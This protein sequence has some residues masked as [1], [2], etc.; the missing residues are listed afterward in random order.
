[1]SEK[2]AAELKDEQVKEA[3][4]ALLR[5]RVLELEQQLESQRQASSKDALLRSL[6][7]ELS[8]ARAV[9]V[10]AVATLAMAS[11]EGENADAKHVQRVVRELKERKPR[12]FESGVSQG[13]REGAMGPMRA[14]SDAEEAAQR[15]LETGHRR[16]LLEYLRLRRK[17]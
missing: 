12:L 1:M 11:L 2:Q 5:Q 8:Q 17:Q 13:L 3:S 14:G 7:R 6:E 9:D 10:E 4:D 16:A 15:A